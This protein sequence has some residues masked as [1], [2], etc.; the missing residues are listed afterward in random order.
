M[1][2]RF[3]VCTWIA[4]VGLLVPSLASGQDRTEREIVELVLR[5]S[6][7]ARAIGPRAMSLAASNW[8]GSPTQTRR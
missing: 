6:P 3:Q 8:H 5:D 4:V 1:P 7:Q 2:T